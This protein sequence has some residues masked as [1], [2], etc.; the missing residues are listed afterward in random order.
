MWIFPSETVLIDRQE[1]KQY[2]NR[3]INM[4]NIVTFDDSAFETNIVNRPPPP[5]RRDHERD[6]EREHGSEYHIQHEDNPPPPPRN[7]NEYMIEG[8][9]SIE[10]KLS[11]GEGFH[12]VFANE[13]ERDADIKRIIGELSGKKK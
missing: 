3:P 7:N 2:T 4:D 10:F 13:V 11:N 9:P 1:G 8:L 12:W 6:H 5:P